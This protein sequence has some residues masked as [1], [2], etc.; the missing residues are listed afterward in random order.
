VNDP[1]KQGVNSNQSALYPF[2]GYTFDPKGSGSLWGAVNPIPGGDDI[3][4]NQSAC[5]LAKSN[6]RY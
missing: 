4:G 1:S 6:I 3:L 5:G 2:P